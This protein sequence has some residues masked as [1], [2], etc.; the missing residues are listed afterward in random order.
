MPSPFFI[1]GPTAVGKTGM[2]VAV[3]ER[4]GAE[5]VN[6]DAFQVY[7]GLD[8]LTAKPSPDER[9][10]VPH[11]LVGTVPLTEIYSVARFAEEAHSCLDDIARRGRPAI[12]VGGSG[13]YVKALTHGLSPLPPAQPALRAEL[14]NMEA[15]VLLRRLWSLDPV[16]AARIDAKNKRRLI[17][18][19]E[20]CVTTG[21]RF[22]D[23]REKW[24]SPDVSRRIG[25]CLSSP[26]PARAACQDQAPGGRNVCAWRRRRGP[27]SFAAE[28][29]GYGQPD[30]RLAGSAR[31]CRRTTR[32]EKLRRANR[33]GH[34]AIRQTSDDLVSRE[35][36]FERF[37][38][39]EGTAPAPM[40]D[41][42]CRRL[43]PD[44]TML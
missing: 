23:F 27:G 34:P 36:V 21:Q 2:A 19:V 13:M 10:R 31:L 32:F 44:E 3:A 11:H 8:L 41:E 30:D 43:S 5:I 18:A 22:S 20:V 9:P 24:D 33:D 37:E 38:L 15:A 29:V 39:S 28:T 6:A 1:V 16:T 26:G 42:I 14:E 12:V 4:L 25:W 7:E 35:A 40:I 17:R